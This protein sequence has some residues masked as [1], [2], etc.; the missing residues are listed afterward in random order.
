MKI[1]EV[2]ELLNTPIEYKKIKESD[3]IDINNISKEI[4]SKDSEG[5]VLSDLNS[6]INLLEK[7]TTI[8]NIGVGLGKWISP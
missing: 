5:Y 1:I 7:D 8:I 6:K 3:F 2:T 4:V